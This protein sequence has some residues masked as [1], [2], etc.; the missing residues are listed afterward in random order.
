MKDKIC[1]VV[2]A[3]ENDMLDFTVQNGDLVIAAD[4]GL[5]YLQ[6]KGINADLIIGDFDSLPQR[7]TQAN[8]IALNS[9]KDDTDTLAAIRE[10]IDRGYKTF[11]IYCGTGGRIEHTIANIQALAFLS[12]DKMRGYLFGRDYVITAITNSSISFDSRCDGYISVFSCSDKATGIYLKGLKYELE[13]AVILNTFPVGV[14]NE[15]IGVKSLVTVEAGTL[16]VVFPRKYMED[17]L[18]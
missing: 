9:E 4:G 10:G 1:Y 17:I 13:N 8:A 16:I 18:E 11:Y 15:F 14:S 3:G 12:Q 5:M 6:E 7:P 2:G